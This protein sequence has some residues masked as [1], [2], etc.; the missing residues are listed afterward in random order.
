MFRCVATLVVAAASLPAWAEDCT[1]LALPPYDVEAASNGGWAHVPLS[2]LK[3]DTTYRVK[4]TDGRKVLEAVAEGAASAYVHLA[5][6]DISRRPFLEWQWR[7]DALIDEADNTDAK[8]EDA[9]LRVM[10]GFDGDV[11]TL[12]DKEQRRFALAKRISGRNLPFATLMYIW[13][14]RQPVETVIASEHSSRVKMIVVESGPQGVGIW[15]SYRRNFKQDYE[16]AFGEAPGRVLGVAVMTDTDNTGAKA[17]G[18][19]GPIRFGCP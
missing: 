14:N 1:P 16:R 19:Y 6:I 8:R 17:S 4:E 2:K 13:E 12:P 15:R 11:S 9:P 7:T 18:L 3:R 5:S 10:V